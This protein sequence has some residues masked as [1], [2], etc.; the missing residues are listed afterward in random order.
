MIAKN[1]A[2]DLRSI[3]PKTAIECHRRPQ[4]EKDEERGHGKGKSVPLMDTLVKIVVTLDENIGRVEYGECSC[5]CKIHGGR[6]ASITYSTTD[7]RIEK[8]A[9]GGKPRTP[10]GAQNE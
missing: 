9:A 5:I 1:K 8:A 10:Q 2:P 4:G 6:L 3:T 7:N